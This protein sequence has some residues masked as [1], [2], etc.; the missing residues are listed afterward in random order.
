[1]QPTNR[2][3]T[4]GHP[5]KVLIQPIPPKTVESVNPE[6][7]KYDRLWETEGYRETAPGETLAMHFLEQAQPERDSE[8]IDFGCGTGRGALMLALFGNMKV[9]MLDFSPNCLD[10]EVA[11]ACTTQGDR[12]SFQQHD[13]TKVIPISASYGFCCDVMEH[14]P[15]EDVQT[16]LKNILA[17][18]HHV[19]FGIS[20][21]PDNFGAT[22]GEELHLT[23]QPMEWWAEQL[24]ALGAVIL[25]S[26]RYEEIGAC[27]FYCSTWK[28][29]GE[30]VKTG[31][32]NVTESV[33]DEQV[34]QNVET[35]WNHVR[36]HD[37]QNREVVLLGGGPSLSEFSD[38]I[39]ELRAAGC[40]LVTTNGAYN[41]ALEQGLTPSMQV[42]LDGREFNKRF[43]SPQVDTCWYCI[44][45][46]AHPSTLEGLP[47][48]RTL[49]WHSGISE[50]NE[51]LIR[52]RNDGWFFPVP[53]GSTVILRA[54]PLL[55]MLGYWRIHIFGFDSCV[56]NGTH[57]AYSQP[58]NDKAITIS[59]NCG[60]RIF[61]CVPWM[62]SQ[63]SEFRDLI[64]FLGD[65]VE[66]EV[67]GTGLIA[68]MLKTGASIA[69]EELLK[70]GDAQRPED[71]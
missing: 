14:I 36:P 61:D 71:A 6:Q 19:F 23:V 53:G 17:S 67:Y 10:P 40:A 70:A 24:T 11:E 58:E 12:L 63:A 25:W 69:D 22:I 13:L 20:T 68:H 1:M 45:S 26:K 43:V 44:A 52:K 42:V 65:E 4:I 50:S 59:V 55:R 16:V 30:L 48:E 38:K 46:Q 33:L 15:P 57:H 31:I 5:P 66:L 62:V 9:R 21:V 47:H 18:A 39:K 56:Y 32:L 54:I 37:R 64:T 49:L 2:A 8:V 29:A 3:G 27:A 51:Q 60:G 28:D 7:Q 34:R 41:W 35:G